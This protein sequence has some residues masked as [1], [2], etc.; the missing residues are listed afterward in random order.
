M[1]YIYIYIYIHTDIYICVLCIPQVQVQPDEPREEGVCL[2]QGHA[3]G[4]A[5]PCT[6]PRLWGETEPEP[7]SEPEYE[8]LRCC[9]HLSLSRAWVLCLGWSVSDP[10]LSL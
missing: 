3:A 8:L 9:L 2:Q 7:Q 5:F 1:I 10:R 4:Y 6:R